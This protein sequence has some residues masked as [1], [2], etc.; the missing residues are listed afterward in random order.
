MRGRFCCERREGMGE[1]ATGLRG[2]ALLRGVAVG[3]EAVSCRGLD[4]WSRRVWRVCVGAQM[5]NIVKCFCW[6]G[7]TGEDWKMAGR[8]VARDL[9]C[10]SI[11]SSAFPHQTVLAQLL[12]LW[13]KGTLCYLRLQYEA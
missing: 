5:Q 12:A 8:A 3:R 4:L 13:L 11:M 10:S 6:P 2:T 1:E 7:T 9:I